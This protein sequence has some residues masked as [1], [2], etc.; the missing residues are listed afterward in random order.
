MMS[1]ALLIIDVQEAMFS[2]PDMKLYDEAGVLE[3]ISSLL[4]KARSAGIPVIYIQHTE[5]EGEFVKG[6][7]T[8]EISSRITPQA[9]EKVIGKTTPDSF[10]LTG[11]QGELER[12]GATDLV[13]CGMQTDYCVNATSRRA[14][15]LG[16]SS[17]LVKDAHSTFD[18]NNLTGEE[19]VKQ[20]ND[21]LGSGLVT[22][23]SEEEV[24]FR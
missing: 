9:G 13:I 4:D 22:L 11:L 18:N 1:T 6:T 15:S 21:A 24:T 14:H 23:R 20:H 17:V 3:R 5:E 7:P 8:W 16:Y 2:Y 10:H 12:L 19:I